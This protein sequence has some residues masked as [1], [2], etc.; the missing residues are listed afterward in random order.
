LPRPLA[1]AS[2]DVAVAL[3]VVRWRGNRG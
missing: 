3:D 2:V 1:E